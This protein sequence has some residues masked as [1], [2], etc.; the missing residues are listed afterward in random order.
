MGRVT[1]G[2]PRLI[3]DDDQIESFNCGI[4]DINVWLLKRGK[5]ARSL[6]TAAVYVSTLED[7]TIAGFYTLSMHSLERARTWG[8]L[9]RNS[10]QQIPAVLLGMLA[11]NKSCQGQG[12]GE[13]LLRNALR[14]AMNAA[15]SIGAKALVV[16][17]YNDTARDFYLKRGFTPVPGS[18]SL[19]AK[20]L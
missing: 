9:A 5:K 18:T 11:V 12:L 15:Q 3:C 6:G 16:E 17:P 8:W 7:G 13:E 2:A 10:P 4:E 19:Y 1:F 20:L 14:R